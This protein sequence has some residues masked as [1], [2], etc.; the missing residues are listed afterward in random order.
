MCRVSRCG[1]GGEPVRIPIKPT[2]LGE[3]LAALPKDRTLEVLSHRT[4]AAEGNQYRHWDTFRRIKPPPGLSLDEAWLATKLKRSATSSRLPLLDGDGAPFVYTTP[5]AALEMFRQIDQRAAGQVA[6]GEAITN[7]ETRDRY[8]VSSLIE[9]AITSS[10]LEGA[11]TTRVVAKQMLRSGRAPRDRSERMILNNFEAMRFISDHKDDALTSRFICDVH[12][13]VTQGTLHDAAMAGRIQ[14]PGDDRVR[15]EDAFGNVMHTPPPAE[16][17]QDRMQLLC[18][19]A[20]GGPTD[21]FLHPVARAILL[22]FWLAYDHPFIDGNGRTARALFYWSM[23]H[24]G[25]WLAEFL[26]ISRILTAGPSKYA[27]SFLYVET[28]D[29]DAT[30][31]ILNQLRVL[32]RSVDDFYGYLAK[33][34]DEVRRVERLVHEDETFNQRQFAL[35]GHALRHADATYSIHSHQLSHG[36]AYESARKDLLVLVARGLLVQAKVGK[37][38]RFYP[39]ADIEDKVRI[40]TRHETRPSRN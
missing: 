15:V 4:T 30:Y 8:V 38:F 39:A 19:F 17:L 25:Y 3:L 2:Q 36:V 29:N 12:E 31:F 21:G 10:Q 16:Q 11:V 26:S 27:R 14:D 33:K 32:C 28:D 1:V 5:D 18:D 9:E 20:N 37:A 22:H 35:L 23:L 7:Q 34:V 40:R 6:V 13:I 24:Q